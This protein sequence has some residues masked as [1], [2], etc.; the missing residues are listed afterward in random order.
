MGLLYVTMVTY[1]D[2]RNRK[3]CEKNENWG[4]NNRNKDEDR[5]R[6]T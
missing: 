4:G 3:N 2:T 6:E 1:R 5:G